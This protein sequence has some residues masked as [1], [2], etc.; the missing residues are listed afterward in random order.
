MFKI[1]QSGGIYKSGTAYSLQKTLQVIKSAILIAKNTLFGLSYIKVGVALTQ[2]KSK[3]S[4]KFQTG[5][6]LF[7]GFA[8]KGLKKF[9][10]VH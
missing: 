1:N 4:K 5:I 8:L 3:A 9:H 6:Y 7:Y 10:K 2:I